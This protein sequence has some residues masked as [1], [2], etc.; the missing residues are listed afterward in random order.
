VL[1]ARDA[2][3]AE[4]SAEKAVESIGRVNLPREAIPTE[5]LNSIEVWDALLTAGNGMPMTAMIRSLAKMTSVGLLT[6]DPSNA[7]TRHV[8]ARLTDGEAIRRARVH[9]ISL[10]AALK[11][12]EQGHGE[13]GK[14]IWAPVK[15]IVT[16]LDEAFY[17][18]F[19]NVT[20]SGRRIRVA[21]D[22]SGSMTM[23]TV[24]GMPFL[25]ARDAA[26]AMALVLLAT[27]PNAEVIG[28]SDR[29]VPLKLRPSMRLD[30][31]LR[32]MSEAPFGWTFCSLPISD[33][34]E[35]GMV[36]D[37]FVSLTDS[38]TADG[39]AIPA[40]YLTNGQLPHYNAN[41]QLIG[42]SD[43]PRN[44]PAEVLRAYRERTGLPVRHVVAAMVANAITINDPADPLALDIAGF[45]TATP[46]VISEFVAGRL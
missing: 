12:Y 34:L 29:I 10:L 8:V 15:R 38:E 41:R 4:A 24:N 7:A 32:I 25:T 22:V 14:L 23:G 27:E 16:A 11:T 26:A 19:K 13:K 43:L 33:A 28:F 36:F 40:Q 45:D 44:T 1:V 35:G 18:A 17:L 5:L 30:E 9:P 6:S 20:P 39:R 31:V 3:H 46:G 37:A 42:H 2:L 21:V